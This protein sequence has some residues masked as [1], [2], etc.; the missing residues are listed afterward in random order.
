[1][2]GC[3]RHYFFEDFG[4]GAGFGLLRTRYAIAADSTPQPRTTIDVVVK[5]PANAMFTSELINPIAATE[6]AFANGETALSA[7]KTCAMSAWTAEFMRSP[8]M[9]EAW[10]SG[11]S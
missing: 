8:V 7:P 10:I 4:A 11:S 9:I 1:M 2:R 6:T 5:L 3:R